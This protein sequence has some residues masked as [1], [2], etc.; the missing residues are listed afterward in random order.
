MFQRTIAQGRFTLP[1]VATFG[2]AV[3][4]L[5]ALVQTSPNDWMAWAAWAGAMGCTALAVY[6]VAE[7]NNRFVLLRI[8]SRMLSS[9]TAMLMGTMTFMGVHLAESA[10]AL[11]LYVGMTIALFATFGAA[12]PGL[13]LTAFL[14]L[15]CISLLEPRMAVLIPIV[16]TAQ[17]MLRSMSLR[18]ILASVMGLSM[19]WW[20]FAAGCF[21]CDRMDILTAQAFKVIAIGWPDY[22]S[23]STKQ[24]VVVGTMLLL[25]LLGAGYCLANGHLDKTRVRTNYNVVMTLGGFAWLVLLLQPQLLVHILPLC[26]LSAAVLGGHVLA[27]SYGRIQNYLCIVIAA[28]LVMLCVW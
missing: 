8:S 27:Q 6:M 25:Y 14:C 1:V 18:T 21:F 20:F 11:T 17:A 26:L 7:M 28:L 4:A 12:R 3:W 5:H 23:G 15:G 9:L 19:P 13:S 24:W 10:L 2:F 22:S 16:W